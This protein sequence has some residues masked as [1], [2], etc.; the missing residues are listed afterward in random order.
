MARQVGKREKSY[1]QHG[2]KYSMEIDKTEKKAG[3][4]EVIL[5]SNKHVVW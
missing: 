4:T 2:K 5:C 3:L 1:Y